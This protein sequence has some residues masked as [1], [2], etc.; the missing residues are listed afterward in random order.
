M[1]FSET[2]L[3]GAYIIDIE[4]IEDERGFFA[5]TWDKNEFSKLG[6]ESEFVQSSISVNKKKGTIRG[7]HYQIKPYEESKVVRC[8]KGRIFDVIIDLRT[9]SKTFK[10]WFSVELS[11]DN[12]KM[13][14][15]PKGFAH[16]FQTLED[17]T[18]IYYEI[19][20]QH[21]TILSKGVKYDDETFD[22]KW[23]LEISIISEKDK[24]FEKYHE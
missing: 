24:S 12:Y 16:G 9:D 20:E 8:I 18:E 23:P 15:I 7:M 14:Y 5:R 13:L 22:I 21:S 4:K 1:I 3:S 17:N 6:L 2:K 11:G 19:S 10:K